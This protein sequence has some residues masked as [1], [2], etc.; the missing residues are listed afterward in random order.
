MK[1]SIQLTLVMAFLVVTSI[2]V[3]SFISFSSTKTT[4][5]EQISETDQKL[6]RNSMDGIDKILYQKYNDIQVIAEA[7]P[8][9]NALSIGDEKSI[10]AVKERMFEFTF[11]TGPWDELELFSKDNITVFSFENQE[12]GKKI[13]NHD[14]EE[15]RALSIA[16]QGNVYVSDL[17]MSEETKRPTV[18]F[19]APIRDK[20]NG[21]IVVGAVTGKFSWP[22]IME[23]LNEF[24]LSNGKHVRLFNKDGTVIG[25]P[26]SHKTEILN[27]NLQH[28]PIIQ[29]ALEGKCGSK[30]V[31]TE[32]HLERNKGSSMHSCFLQQ[33]HLGYKGNGWGLL[34]ETHQNVILDPINEL[35]QRLL[36]TGLISVLLF[37]PVIFFLSRI[38]TNPISNLTKSNEL[39]IKGKYEKVKY[40]DG[41]LLSDEIKDLLKTRK[42]MIKKLL[43]NMKELRKLPKKLEEK[44]KE[45]T[46]DLEESNKK[47]KSL[48]KAK[49]EFLS[50]SSHELRSPLTPIRAQVQML[51]K[52]Y[53]GSLNTKQ[54]E[55]LEVILRNSQKL[56][57]V[58]LDLLD[59]S[60]IETGRLKINIL[61][62]DL[63][64]EL[65]R[66]R[67]DMNHTMMEKHVN[68]FLKT[69][70][71]PLIET[72]AVRVIQILRILT[73]NAVK[74]SPSRGD[75]TIDSVI[76]KKE[77]IFS[78]KDE[79]IG[80][81]KEKQKNIFKPFYQAEETIYR[82]YEGIGL[83]LSIAKGIAEALGG[84]MWFESN[85]GKGTT[86]YFTTP[87][88]YSNNAKK[89]DILNK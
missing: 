55:S 11:Q 79:G 23:L 47:L 74:F 61:Q 49:T 41:F 24:E 83:G 2:F 22:V 6:A 37:I 31:E 88:K 63:Q 57:N 35:R 7:N 62:T 21:N 18:I 54:K 81:S 50:V 28:I 42:L 80:I 70:K 30:L 14:E 46:R 17:I 12:V 72:D 20:K 52:D 10:T 48:D 15:V 39:I 87:L 9:E 53:F 58:I 89:T 51:L 60:R 36:I 5:L 67:V 16:F 84:R 38:V 59:V 33:G 77:V 56:D 34:I 45:R 75:V 78:V 66:F 68:I 44:V 25:T 29:D 27:N 4:L 71:I 40:D 85:K 26:T 8:I 19:A 76:T 64:E 69:Q 65:E 82:T 73:N 1:L 86:F 13:N 32:I 3:S 43:D